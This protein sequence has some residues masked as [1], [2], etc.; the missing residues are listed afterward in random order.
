[1]DERIIATLIGI[2]TGWVLSQLTDF[3]KEKRIRNRKIIAI[4]TELE[5]LSAWLERMKKT[6]RYS[7]MLA[8]HKKNNHLIPTHL[9]KFLIDEHFHEICIYLTRDK[10]ICITDI[11]NNINSINS[12]IN[13]LREVLDQQKDNS[14]KEIIDKNEGLYI[15]AMETKSKIDFL[16]S[17]NK[18]KLNMSVG[19]AD[20]I[21]RK[22]T[23]E[24][25]AIRDEAL[26]LTP[27]KITEAYYNEKI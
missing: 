2:S 12:S 15:N 4:N 7:M 16:L 25:V 20:E 18:Y 5:D 21:S 24:L 11:Y 22:L 9:Q 19:Q 27:E 13:E 26:K 6:T 10:R 3:F 14:F 17:K 23:S 1:M 8:L